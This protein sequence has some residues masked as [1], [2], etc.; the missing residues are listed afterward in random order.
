MSSAQCPHGEVE[1]TGGVLGISHGICCQRGCLGLQIGLRYSLPAEP[2][3]SRTVGHARHHAVKAIEDLDGVEGGR[4]RSVCPP[5]V[6][7]LEVG[8]DVANTTPETFGVVWNDLTILLR[9]EP[10]GR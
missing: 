6:A 2:S 10:L 3:L 7:T 8:H 1:C 4:P 5:Q 9:S